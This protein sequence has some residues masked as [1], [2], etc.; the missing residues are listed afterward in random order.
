[1]NVAYRAFAVFENGF[2]LNELV[3]TLAVGSALASMAFPAFENMVANSRLTSQHNEFLR[4]LHLARSEAI[5]RGEHIVLCKS[6]ELQECESSAEWHDGWIV[7]TDSNLNKQPDGS[8]N[9]VLTHPAL[10][11]SQTLTYAAFPSSNYVVYRPTGLTTGNGTFTLCDRRGASHARALVL[12][13]T[14]RV[15]NAKEKPNGNPLTCP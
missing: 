7:F 5:K 9:I 15:R 3:I 4:H 1:M 14:G 6:R 8:D 2:T 13:K 12:Y 11:Q 10:P